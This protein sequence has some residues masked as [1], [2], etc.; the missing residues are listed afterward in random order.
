MEDL[1]LSLAT[2]IYDDQ[3]ALLG[4][5]G[6]HMILSNINA[7]LSASLN[8]NNGSGIIIDIN[9]TELIANSLGIDN[10]EI[11]QDNSVH[12]IKVDELENV[13]FE[14]AYQEYLLNQTVS[15]EFKDNLEYAFYAIQ[16]VHESGVD[17]LI[18]TSI[19]QGSLFTRIIQNIYWMILT[20]ILST[21]ALVVIYHILINNMFKPVNELV[22]ISSEYA[23]GNFSNRM[24]LTGKDEFS[25]LASAFNS[26]A[27]NINGI[28]GGLEHT[29]YER[30]KHLELVNEQLKESEQRFKILHNASFGGIALHDHGLILDCNQ[31]LSDVTG[32]TMDELVGMDG[33]LLIAPDYREFVMDKITSGYEKP[34]EVYGIRKNK[35]VYPLQLEA[36]NIPYEGR[37]VRVV[38]FRDITDRKQLEMDIIKEK[39]SLAFTLKSIG[40]AVIATDAKG[41]I[42]GINPIACKLTGWSESEAIDKP[43][44]DV[45]NITFEDDNQII[46]DPIKKALLTNSTVELADHTVLISK[47]K[48]EYYIEDTAAPIKN[49]KGEN[50]GVVLVFRDVTEKKKTER[51][52][53]HISEH[54][55]LTDL[56]NRRFYYEKINYY[57]EQKFLP[58]G[59]MMMD[60]NGLKII[61]DAFGHHAG[62]KALILIGNFLKETF[63]EKDIVSRI[64]GDEFT[65]ILPNTSKNALETY[66]DK[67]IA[68]VKNKDIN[69]VELSLSIGYELI[70]NMNQE[71][72]EA[73]KIA[74]N[75]M[76]AHKSISGASIRSRAI[77]AILATLTDKYDTEKKHSIEVSRLCKQIGVELGLKEDKLKELELAGLFHDIGKI[78]IPD[79]I[80]N[81]PG[82]LTDEEFEVIKAHTQVGYQILRAADEFSDLAVHALHHH[83]RWDGKGYPIG[84]K[85]EDIPLFSRIICIVDAYEAMTSDRPYRNKMRKDYAISELNRYA[86]TQFDPKIAKVF[87]EKVLKGKWEVITGK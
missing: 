64:G 46:E 29:V 43:F 49:A 14:R 47:D 78:S 23:K 59:L 87:V 40:D 3:G 32:F 36:K 12:R 55:Y 24:V 73:Q 7:F 82:K 70:E 28:L 42:T 26:M 2:P 65:V 22:D 51:E 44:G 74:E 71:I 48:T 11:L 50:I 38:E 67:L 61:N 4:V 35:E 77:N 15:F 13:Y 25:K 31:G 60:V 16:E 10:Y 30:T 81:K 5:L 58:L 75:Q 34:Y 21:I 54:D 33:M 8:G 41:F 76:Y 19:P 56:H 6:T 69:N 20:F 37:Q 17:W 9:S 27:D 79:N 1:A 53:K 85:N 62:D 83:E 18:I 80:L 63:E 52:L 72:D 66:K 39:E 68:G 57:H 84:L 86:G 45:F